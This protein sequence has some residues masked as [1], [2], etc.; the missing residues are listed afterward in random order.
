MKSRDF[1]WTVLRTPIVML[2]IVLSISGA[3]LVSSHVFKNQMQLEHQ[4][5]QRQFNSI[6]SQYLEVDN[7]ERLIADYYPHFIELYS[8]GIV[9]RERRL[10]WIDALRQAGERLKIPSLR[11]EISAQ[12]ESK[13]A[14]Q[15]NLGR[16]ALRASTM[17]LKLDMV[18]EEDLTRLLATLD[19]VAPGIFTVSECNLARKDREVRIAE[20]AVNVTAECE[21][22]WFNLR[23]ASGEEIVIL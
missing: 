15:V 21:L 8:Q 2:V 16:Y 9:G 14:L 10:D 12:S 17:K 23:L 3:I 22:I 4:D 11:Y 6:S 7:Q 5:K 20:G 19:R 1:D 18:H 13:E